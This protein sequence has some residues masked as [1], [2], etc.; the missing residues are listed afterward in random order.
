VAESG[1]IGFVQFRQQCASR[2]THDVAPQLV[3]ETSGRPT[4][5]PDEVEMLSLLYSPHAAIGNNFAQVP[6]CI[7]SAASLLRTASRPRIRAGF[8]AHAVPH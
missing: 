3:G 8:P 7:S 6:H 5:L 2:S 1:R 4:E